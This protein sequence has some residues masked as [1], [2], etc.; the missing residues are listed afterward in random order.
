MDASSSYDPDGTIGRY[1]W[2]WDS[3]GIL[4]E[5]HTTPTASHTYESAGNYTITLRVT[6]DDGATDTTTSAEGGGWIVIVERKR[7]LF[8]LPFSW[9]AIFMIIAIGVIGV[10]LSAFFLKKESIQHLGYAPAAGTMLTTVFL[11]GTILLYHAGVD[12]YWLI[13]PLF[14][15]ALFLF[16]TLTVV[17]VKKRKVA[18]TVFKIGKKKR[19]KK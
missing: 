18:R 1:E 13:I 3:D 16:V 19:R 6:D 15:V 10:S 7:D 11:V 12:W 4:N 9:F 14:L 5:N 2:D 17:L 8:K